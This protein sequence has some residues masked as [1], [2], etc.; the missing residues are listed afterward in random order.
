MN[1]IVVQPEIT[2]GALTNF[3]PKETK[4][5]DAKADAVISTAHRLQ[6]WPLLETA[7]EK[8]V[9]E[10]A[11]FVAWWDGAVTPNRAQ[12]SVNAERRLQTAD[13][14]EKLTGITQQQ[15]SRWRTRLK[16]RSKFKSML[17]GAAYNKAMESAAQLNQQ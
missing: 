8:K 15:V 13:E 1:G 4:A 2:K 10:I 17:Y 14:A 7:V 5:K 9:D 12:K 16:D 11:E 3:D 6:D